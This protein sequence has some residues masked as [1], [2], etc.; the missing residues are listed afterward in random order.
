M[1]LC[2]RVC[3]TGEFG[4]QIHGS[5]H[6]EDLV[7]RTK[8]RLSGKPEIAA[9]EDRLSGT[10][11]TGP[12][13]ARAAPLPIRKPQAASR[14]T[15]CF[16]GPRPTFLCPSN[17]GGQSE[18]RRGHFHPATTLRGRGGGREGRGRRGHVAQPIG[19]GPRSAERSGVV[20]WSELG[21]RAEATPPPRLQR[22]GLVVLPPGKETLPFRSDG[23]PG[24]W[25]SLRG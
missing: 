17:P 13:A 5:D 11:G 24:E 12:C 9:F 23:I 2:A 22:P 18:E 10:E 8:Q 6:A 19:Q 14:S 15:V 7:N 25:R 3:C 21:R 20:H 4:H 16:D 1:Y